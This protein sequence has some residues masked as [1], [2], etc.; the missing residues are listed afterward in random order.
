MRIKPKALK[1]LAALSVLALAYFYIGFYVDSEFFDV[2][3]FIKHRPYAQ[4]L[5][6]SPLGEADRSYTPGT[7]GYLT[8][9]MERQQAL[10]E[11]FVY[12]N[13][14]YARSMRVF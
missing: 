13:R 3:L 1:P 11:E 9:E 12:K 4:L 7:E 2:H 8:P 10:F 6:V 14:G 5:F